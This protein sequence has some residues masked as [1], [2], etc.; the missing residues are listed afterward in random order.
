MPTADR[1]PRATPAGRASDELVLAAVARAEDHG[2]PD[3]PEIPFWAILEHLAVPRR[4][5]AA[6]HVRARL[7]V[8]HE[9][10]SLQRSRRHGVPTWALTP[11]GRRRLRR[12]ERAGRLGQLPESPQHRAWRNARTAAAQEIER[13]RRGL[14]D[15]LDEAAQ[16]LDAA[17]PA[18]SD[19]WFELGQR[20][21][22]GCWRVASASYCLYEWAEPQDAR[23]DIEDYS[24]PS[25]A[26]LDP[27]ERARRRARRLGRRNI[28]LWDDPS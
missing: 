27:G 7:D 8:L 22:R 19:A 25:D 3:T 4:S 6:R 11:S 17:Q 14:G 5:A 28:R 18:D 21:R 9:A 10:G 24:D 1:D 15:S 26:A 13:F 16:L 20:L 23:A 12:A 2:T